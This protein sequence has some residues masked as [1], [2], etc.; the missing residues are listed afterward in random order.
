[1]VGW[2]VVC[3]CA[4]GEAWLGGVWCVSVHDYGFVMECRTANT[5]PSVAVTGKPCHTPFTELSILCEAPGALASA[6]HCVQ[7]S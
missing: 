4:W 1:M 5:S 6:S 7:T 3:E 2:S